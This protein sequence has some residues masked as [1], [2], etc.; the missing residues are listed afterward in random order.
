M[1]SMLFKSWLYKFNLTYNG[2]RFI[3]GDFLMIIMLHMSCFVFEHLWW[4][5]WFLCYRV[6]RSLCFNPST[7]KLNI[8][9]KILSKVPKIIIQFTWL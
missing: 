6:E 1:Y 8:Q 9:G 2:E 4:L 3:K 7:S 5:L